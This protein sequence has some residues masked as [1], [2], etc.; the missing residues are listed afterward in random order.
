MELICYV[1]IVTNP[2]K[3]AKVLLINVSLV[4]PVF[5]GK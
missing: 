4:I 3:L 1:E 2:A 5:S